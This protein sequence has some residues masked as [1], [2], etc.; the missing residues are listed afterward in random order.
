MK[1][2]SNPFLSALRSGKP[3]I[4]LWV[5]LCSPFAAEV[6]AGAGFD[7]V[8]IDMEHS[9]NEYT[10]VLNQL[11]VFA[12]Y[13]TTPVIRPDWN[14]AVKV[15]RLLDIG[16]QGLLFPMVQN[17]A[18][19]AAA[20]AAVRYPPHGVRGVSGMTRANRFA[21]T[22]DYFARVEEET[23]VLVQLES[24]AAIAKAHEIAAVSGV[25]GV[26]F[27]PADIGADMGILGQ[28][29]NPAI[30][31]VIMP[32]ARSLIRAGV[33]VGTLVFDPVFAKKLLEEG[34][35]FV[36]CGADTALLARG[37]D[38]LLKAVKG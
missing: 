29:A 24:R 3:Q 18:E 2:Q 25:S 16:A 26:F 5:S 31:D 32:A 13:D 27:G 14:D 9:P 33:P 4:G 17:P 6:V 1:L 21:R 15:K 20:V 34:F 12:A 35:T 7:W 22:T 36:A 37:A 19:A 30:W 38:N 28:P 8:L 10:T 23:A 11:Q